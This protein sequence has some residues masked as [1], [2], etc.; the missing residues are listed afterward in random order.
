MP[1][2]RFIFIG[3]S[4]VEPR[5]LDTFL[6]D[7]DGRI[8]YLGRVTEE[9]KGDA[10]V[11]CDLLCMPSTHEILPAV[12]LEAWSYGKA[13]IGG[14]AP[15][16][17]ELIIDNHAG[18]ISTQVPSSLADKILTLLKDRSFRM[19]LG[20]NGKNLVSSRFSEE[21]LVGNYLSSYREV[22]NVPSSTLIDS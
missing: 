20:T 10:L 19:E 9:E 11:A 2:V 21:A 15:G 12:Y 1:K 8:N 17:H 5:A 6:S 14:E 13:V 16:L 18:M 7:L 22:L 3:P 4:G